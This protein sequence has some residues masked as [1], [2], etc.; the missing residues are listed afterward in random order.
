MGVT[1]ELTGIYGEEKELELEMSPI[2]V[3]FMFIE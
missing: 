1:I 3:P 2:K